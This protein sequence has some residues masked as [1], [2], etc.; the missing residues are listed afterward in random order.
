MTNSKIFFLLFFC[1][2]FSQS[3]MLVAS[4]NTSPLQPNGS[5]PELPTEPPFF[6]VEDEYG[7]TDHRDFNR[8]AHYD[9]CKTPLNQS[10]AQ[11]EGTDFHLTVE[12]ATASTGF[13]NVA[14]FYANLINKSNQKKVSRNSN[15][16]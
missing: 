1:S 8:F 12:Q 5:F 13:S 15:S 4:E 7:N 10:A 2:I 16:N 9:A 6:D 3:A 14:T 11:T